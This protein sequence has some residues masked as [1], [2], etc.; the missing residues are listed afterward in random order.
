MR[1]IGRIVV[2]TLAACIALACSVLVL[3]TLGLERLTQAAH[4][5]DAH[6]DDLGAVVQMMRIAYGLLETLMAFPTAVLV[7]A[8]SLVII[9][10]IARIRSALFYLV[11]GGL[12]MSI[13]PLLMRY[14][15]DP[16]PHAPL[17]AAGWQVFAT[18][19]FAGGLVYWL[20]AGRR[21]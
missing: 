13:L 15:V 6:Q 16:R 11:G 7:P 8:L 20:L 12:V 5:Y 1:L 19:G 2:V 9:G 3:G 18:A 10:E 4:R 21:A 14:D 17:L